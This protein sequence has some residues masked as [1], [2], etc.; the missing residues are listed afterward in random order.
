MSA[1]E[2]AAHPGLDANTLRHMVKN[3]VF[4]PQGWPASPV[5]SLDF[6]KNGRLLA[7]G[8]TQLMSASHSG[9]GSQGAAR[10]GAGVVDIYDCVEG[11]RACRTRV[12][13]GLSQVIFTHSGDSVLHSSHPAAGAGGDHTVWYMSL[14]TSSYMRGFSGHRTEV[15]CLA[16]CPRDDT[17]LSASTDGYVRLWDLRLPVCKGQLNL[18]AGKATACFNPDGEVFAVSSASS[19]R[20]DPWMCFSIGTRK[21]AC[22]H[23]LTCACA[24]AHTHVYHGMYAGWELVSLSHQHVQDSTV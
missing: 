15:T 3:A 20:Y 2:S 6:S 17:F 8:G 13:K 21:H 12:P 24:C 5:S 11:R 4:H 18:S 9:A 14:A 1:H 10:Q 16:L 19:G 23:V 7:V 22:V